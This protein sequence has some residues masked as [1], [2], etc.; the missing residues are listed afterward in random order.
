MRNPF[1]NDTED[2]CENTVRASLLDVSPS[3]DVDNPSAQ[4]Q[5]TLSDLANNIATDPISTWISADELFTQT[6]ID[7]YMRFADKGNE[8]DVPFP[9]GFMRKLSFW[10]MVFFTGVIGVT[11]ALAACA[12]LTFTDQVQQCYSFLSFYPRS[13]CRLYS[14]TACDV[15]LDPEIVGVV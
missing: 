14:L 11:T 1:S 4:H 8:G 6:M 12:F 5:L 13:G 3:T 7:E 15:C 9:P 10:K 2:L